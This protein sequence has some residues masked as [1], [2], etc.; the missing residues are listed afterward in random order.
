[1]SKSQPSFAYVDNSCIIFTGLTWGYMTC[2]V[3]SHAWLFVTLWIVARQA[4][5]SIEF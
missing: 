5:L 4:P 1:M 3:L 2:A